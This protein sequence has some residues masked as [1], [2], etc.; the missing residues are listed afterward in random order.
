[1]SLAKKKP[2]I[3]EKFCFYFQGLIFK[4][5]VQLINLVKDHNDQHST[6]KLRSMKSF[7]FSFLCRQYYHYAYIHIDL[8]IYINQT[9]K[10]LYELCNINRSIRFW[11]EV[12]RR[13]PRH[14]AALHL[15]SIFRPSIVSTWTKQNVKHNII[16]KFLVLILILIH[17]QK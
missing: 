8:Y 10:I 4:T 5:K 17:N 12:Y 9:Y 11:D 2:K 14:A 1:M 16:Q 3:C 13:R 6:Q 15:Q 7:V